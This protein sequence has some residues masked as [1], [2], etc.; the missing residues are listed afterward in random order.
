[1]VS[2]KPYCSDRVFP[3]CDAIFRQLNSVINAVAKKMSAA[4]Q[5]EEEKRKKLVMEKRIR[6]KE[7]LESQIQSR[8][9]LYEKVGRQIRRKQTNMDNREREINRTLIEK[10]KHD[11]PELLS[12]VVSPVKKNE[13]TV[14]SSIY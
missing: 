13:E 4:A 14:G 10:I 6:Y 1:M 3:G 7:E 11:V 12:P 8:A 9:H 5:A 2:I